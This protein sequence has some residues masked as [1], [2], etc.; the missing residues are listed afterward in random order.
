MNLKKLFMIIFTAMSAVCLAVSIA[1]CNPDEEHVHTYSE[2]WT[3]SATE[4]WHEATCE[5]T[6]EKGNLGTHIDEDNNDK[7]DICDYTMQTEG[8]HQHT[9]AKTWTY[10]GKTHWH[11]ATCDDTTERQDEAPHVDEDGDQYCD[12]CTGLIDHEHEFSE[13]EWKFDINKHWRP[14]TC[15]HPTEKGYEA[16]HNFDNGGVCECGLKE[17]EKQAYNSLIDYKILDGEETDFYT[18]LTGLKADGVT[19]IRITVK[20]DIVYDRSGV[21]EGVYVAERTVKVK[22]T[23]DG[24]DGL[25]DV[26]FKVAMSE[27][28]TYHIVN[29][30]VD[31]L[32]VAKTGADG[33]AE[34]TFKP[35]GGYSNGEEIK[36]EILL[37]EAKDVAALEGG[38]EAEIEV[39][40]N[41][42]SIKLPDGEELQSGKAVV[43]DFVVNETDTTGAD[44]S[45]T[46]DFKFD[47]SWVGSDKQTLPYERR[48]DNEVAGTDSNGEDKPTEY[49]KVYNF[50]ATGGNIFD[51]LLFAPAH[52]YN[53]NSGST[54]EQ[55]DKITE[56]YRKSASG[57]YE[58]SFTV[59]GDGSARLY[60]WTGNLDLTSNQ[61]PDG[62][63]KDSCAVSVSG[64]KPEDSAI[65]D[66]IFTG[67]NKVII[68]IK[69]DNGLEFFQLGI[70]CQ[71]A[72]QVTI[73]VTRTDDYEEI[74]GLPLSVGNNT[75]GGE[76]YRI[77]EYGITQIPIGD[78][79]P[80]LYTI[81]LGSGSYTAGG[82][83]VY[84]KATDKSFLWNNHR[85]SGVI[86]IDDGDEFLN[87]YNG[88]S[89]RVCDINISEYSVP[90]ITDTGTSY[91][92]ASGKDSEEFEIKFADSVKPG[93]VKIQVK[94]Y[95][96]YFYYC[97]IT[98]KV[99]TKTYTPVKQGL[100][101]FTFE[102]NIVIA[103]GDTLKI[104]SN[105]NIS[106]F[107]A[108]L[109][110]GERLDVENY[111]VIEESV[112]VLKTKDN[113][114]SKFIPKN[115]GTYKITLTTVE[116][117][118]DSLYG[119]PG[120]V[121][122]AWVKNKVT[123]ETILKNTKDFGKPGDGTIQQTATAEFEAN[124]GESIV[125]EFL[126]YTSVKYNIL[127][128]YVG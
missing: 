51:Y 27:K 101:N 61:K 122:F 60:Y 53:W 126:N 76:G 91:V 105:S 48:Y 7:C 71:D 107:T 92:P 67:E 108:E 37:A 100:E 114:I 29:D 81:A 62:T 128:E 110:F 12:I 23:I 74:V 123:G 102:T 117:P 94:L 124:S 54:V 88:L 87:V 59:T 119:V 57:I 31:A 64:T 116:S 58:I 90:T 111:P 55:F 106:K 35:I 118:F 32:A 115:T 66:G 20:G 72:C 96:T 39:M 13:T 36:Y 34:L 43:T 26:W 6:D 69:P 125:L 24:G 11:A 52:K 112:T 3:R 8:D 65:A 103:A 18:W 50:T 10:D 78:I 19:D 22:A 30:N 15:G 2:E 85:Y 104:T 5:H 1:G 82:V 120:D 75:N 28:G 49:G 127:I 99:G 89:A 44:I 47:V 38:E 121:G 80:G 9:F 45:G 16:E 17:V 97:D 46:L 70:V 113:H 84:T 68:T 41:R 73:T 95:T 14:A 109:T 79:N 83:L 98:I 56:N 86:R 33:I 4:H 42:Y 77:N 63:P 40:P 93:T 21:V 25:A